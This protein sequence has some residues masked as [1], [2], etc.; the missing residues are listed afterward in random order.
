MKKSNVFSSFCRLCLAISDNL[1]DITSEQFDFDIID[2][3]FETLDIKFVK[4]NS[5][6]PSQFV[7]TECLDIV[8]F[9]NKFKQGCKLSLEI[10]TKCVIHDMPKDFSEVSWTGDRRRLKELMSEVN[11]V[12]EESL[13]VQAE[14]YKELYNSSLDGKDQEIKET[15]VVTDG[16]VFD[17]D[18][19]EIK[20]EIKQEEV[21]VNVEGYDFDAVYTDDENEE[22]LIHE[23]ETEVETLIEETEEVHGQSIDKELKSKKSYKK[24]QC[25]ICQKFFD[26]YDFKYHMN[27]HLKIFPFRCEEPDCD[28]KF[29][30]P[31]N[32]T[33]HKKSA[34]DGKSI[35]VEAKQ[36]NLIPCDRCGLSFTRKQLYN[37]FKKDHADQQYKCEEPDCGQV[38]ANLLRLRK[39]QKRVHSGTPK[40]K[41]TC[42]L[43]GKAFR[44][45]RL[46]Y[47]MNIHLSKSRH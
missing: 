4:Q 41:Y 2:L 8:Q 24:Y 26:G 15:E 40:Q 38:F 5:V 18:E 25:E 3:V 6:F 22:K 16:N 23:S 21:E 33:A 9:I 44:K 47:H 7:C 42:E 10:L 19:A 32:L 17:Q 1:I 30:S 14:H 45:T 12:H 31:G 13:V 11:Q 27:T 29:T 28:R 20:N 43:C 39:H 36:E 46:K 37:H 35:K 34:H